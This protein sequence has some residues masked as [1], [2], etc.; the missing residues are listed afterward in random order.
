MSSDAF[1]RMDERDGHTASPGDNSN[2]LHLPHA[3]HPAQKAGGRRRT[4]IAGPQEQQFR[5]LL[6]EGWAVNAAVKQA[7]ISPHRALRIVGEL[8]EVLRDAA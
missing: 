8:F 2:E 4:A 7:G 3:D 1:R 6:R 5:Q